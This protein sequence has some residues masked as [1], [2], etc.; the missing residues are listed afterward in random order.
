M[1]T[2]ITPWRIWLVGML[3][4]VASP[5]VAADPAR[6]AA[7][8]YQQG[9]AAERAGDPAAA[10]EAYTRALRANPRHADARFRLGQLRMNAASIA[11]RGRENRIGAV[12]IPAIQLHEA[13]F[14]ESIELLA[15]LLETHS[16]GEITPNF[17]IQDPDGKFAG[18]SISLRMRNIPARAVI[19]QLLDHGNAKIRYDEHAVVITPR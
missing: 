15:T 6:D 7:R 4:G 17:I 12:M 19:A 5:V 18:T 8:Y 3:M 16:D 14:G 10:R 1:K 13:S 9:V 11:A 2:I